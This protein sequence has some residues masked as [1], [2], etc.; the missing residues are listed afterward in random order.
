MLSGQVVLA[1]GKPVADANV[2]LRGKN[3]RETRTDGQ[4]RFR[5]ESLLPGRYVVWAVKGN[6]VSPAADPWADRL[7]ASRA[8]DLS[9]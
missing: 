7:S 1:D 5:F 4:G 8:Y 3:Q 6:L 9:P 2:W